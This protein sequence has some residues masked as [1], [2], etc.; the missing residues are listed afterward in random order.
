[1]QQERVLLRRSGLEVP[2]LVV[3]EIIGLAVDAEGLVERNGDRCV[4]PAGYLLA[5]DAELAGPG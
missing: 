4:T 1:V 3:R 5:I 2:D